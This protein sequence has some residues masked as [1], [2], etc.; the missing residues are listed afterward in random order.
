MAIDFI[1][2]GMSTAGEG[3]ETL[4][5]TLASFLKPVRPPK[6]ASVPYGIGDEDESEV[7][8]RIFSLFLSGH[9]RTP[10]AS[11]LNADHIPPPCLDIKKDCSTWSYCDI[12]RI[13]D[14]PVYKDED[15]IDEETWNRTQAEASRRNSAYGRRQPSNSPLRGIITCGICGNHFSRRERGRSSIWLCKTYLKHGSTACPSRCIRE[16]LLFSIL[17]GVVGH[18]DNIT[19]WPDGRLVISTSEAEFERTWR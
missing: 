7:V 1:N 17:S 6:P 11:I 12:R 16:N 3:G 8:R 19:V 4:L 2:E 9:G 13:L 5:S 18:V 14:N 15:L 10:I